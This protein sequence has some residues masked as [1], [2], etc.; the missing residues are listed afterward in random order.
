VLGNSYSFSSELQDEW[1]W[2]ERYPSAA[3][4]VRY[5]EH[6]ADRFDL[7]LHF[8]VNTR[9]VAAE[10][11]ETDDTW[12]ITASDGSVTRARYFVPATGVLSQ[13]KPPEIPGIESFAG[14]AY[15]TGRWPHHPVDLTGKRVG[16]IGTGSSGVQTIQA[17]AGN[18]AKYTRFGI[19][20]AFPSQSVLEAT[21]EERRHAF[22][23]AWGNSSLLGFRLCYGDILT[24]PEANEIAA[25]FIRAKVREIVK[26]PVLA[27]KLTPRDFP[28]GTKRPRLGDTYYSLHNREDVTLVHLKSDP[29]LRIVPN[30]VET[31][32]GLHELDCLIYA[33]GYDALTGALTRIDIRGVGGVRLAVKWADGAK[34]YLGLMTSGC[35]N[36]FTV[37][38]PG[39]PGP[40]ANVSIGVEQHADWIDSCIAYMHR[41]GYT[42]IDTRPETETAWM[43]LVRELAER[44]LYPKANSWYLGANVPGKPARVPAVPGRARCV[45]PEM[46]RR[47]RGWL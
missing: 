29:I 34:T 25:E 36:M 45:P 32:S 10:F 17:L 35:P 39:S 15:H 12:L 6:V 44:T 7:R 46:R 33:T 30:G 11:D 26:D 38:G 9:V 2:T 47:R 24:N 42:R 21:P 16:V 3:E 22:E 27:E 43:E 28:F 4:L 5:F 1:D 23:N 8:R 19:Y 41:H 13:P 37:T 31:K 18:V 14:N 40:L 20:A